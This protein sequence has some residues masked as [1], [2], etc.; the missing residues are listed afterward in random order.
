MCEPAASGKEEAVP[1][2]WARS[3]EAYLTTK[4]S[5]HLAGQGDSRGGVSRGDGQTKEFSEHSMNVGWRD[6]DSE[7]FWWCGH[8]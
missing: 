8:G 5:S 7:V 2:L 1:S 6:H 3:G 4:V